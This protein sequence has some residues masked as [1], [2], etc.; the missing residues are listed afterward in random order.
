MDE[1]KPTKVLIKQKRNWFQIVAPKTFGGRIIGETL[2]SDPAK[3]KGRK[4]TI[5]AGVAFGDMKKQHVS[6]IF[7][8]IDFE[9]NSVN[10]NVEGLILSQS[11]LKRGTRRFKGK[12][13]DSFVVK[14]SEGNVRVKVLLLLRREVHRS[15]GS[16]LLKTVR[17]MCSKFCD[18]KKFDD[19]V[20]SILNDSF[21]RLIKD[22]LK[23]IYPVADVEIRY[24]AKE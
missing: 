12:L 10:S 7:N 8:L 6:L 21:N 5:S 19:L 1:K 17:D 9:G 16:N 15:V 11:Y 20:M 18:G 23:K 13:E 2:S 14:C 4:L 22:G 3:I 24:F